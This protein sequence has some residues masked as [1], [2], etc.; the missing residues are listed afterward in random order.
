MPKTKHRLSRL[1]SYLPMLVSHERAWTQSARWTSWAPS[2]ELPGSQRIPDSSPYSS[3][4][5]PSPLSVVLAR[6]LCISCLDNRNTGNQPF[7]PVSSPS[8]LQQY[9][10]HSHLLKIKFCLKS[11]ICFPLGK[12][13]K[14]KIK[15]LW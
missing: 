15:S 2:G 13:D 1:A 10:L 14:I 3:I 7:F 6:V 11:F 9:C 4:S 8:H 5:P 12:G